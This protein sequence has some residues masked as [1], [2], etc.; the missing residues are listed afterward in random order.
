MSG[1]VILIQNLVGGAAAA[2][3]SPWGRG[4]ARAHDGAGG[5]HGTHGAHQG[6]Q[7][8]WNSPIG[9]ELQPQLA[10]NLSPSA[11]TWD[12]PEFIHNT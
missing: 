2:A 3:T 11:D 1:L 7:G 8:P 5:A 10:P 4:P 9:L 6:P 12:Y